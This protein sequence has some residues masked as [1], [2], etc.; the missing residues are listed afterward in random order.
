MQKKLIDDVCRRSYDENAEEEG[1]S[2]RFMGRDCEERRY[3]FPTHSAEIEFD[4]CEILVL[5]EYRDESVGE[6]IISRG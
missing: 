2:E 5:S 1:W 4:G 3:L 6:E